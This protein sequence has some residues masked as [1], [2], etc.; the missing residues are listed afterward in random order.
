[1]F[2]EDLIGLLIT[3][4]QMN[5]YDSKIV[6]SFYDQIFRGNGL[7]EKQA[8][9]AV[10]ILKRQKNKLEIILSQNIDSFLENPTFR[11]QKR[12]VPNNKVLEIHDN[13]LFKR[14]IHATF[15]YNEEIIQKIRKDRSKLNHAQWD[16]EK[17]SWI[18]SL[19]EK[20]LVFIKD[21]FS[22]HDFKV[23]DE[24]Q[25]YFNEID[26]IQRTMENFV[27]M[28]SFRENKVHFDNFS[29]FLPKI[30][31]D[32]ILDA[33]F[34]ARKLGIQTWDDNIEVFLEKNYQTHSIKQFLNTSP[35]ESFEFYL[36]NNN[37]TEIGDLLKFLTPCIF[38]I[39]GGSEQEKL[40]LGLSALKTIGVTPD[41]ISV[42]FRLPNET[43]ESFNKFVRSNN[44]NNPISDS[45]RAIFISSKV[46]KPMIESKVKFNFVVNFNFY[47]IHYTI[48]EFLKNHHNVVH[49]FDK[50]PQKSINFAIL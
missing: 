37:F 25:N 13:D 8:D 17:K 4:V 41:Q 3:R 43:G 38:V 36:E 42:L 45:T 32:N 50:K 40:E 48:R 30:E 47:N 28:V 9:L 27:P 34:F 5:P 15:P 18:F 31:T 12:S 35:S 33:L 39:P 1:M 21:N 16:P 19:D 49:V 22:S 2:V 26:K 7:T 6:S 46:P 10:K 11:L 29:Q 14:A 20:S 23:S 44:L 24:L